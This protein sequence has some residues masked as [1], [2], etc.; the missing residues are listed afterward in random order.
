MIRQFPFRAFRA[1]L[2]ATTMLAAGCTVGPDFLRPKPPETSGYTTVSLATLPEA[3]GEV[4]QRV[5]VGKPVAPEWW[6]NFASPELD[7]VIAYA[8]SDSPTLEA[9]RANLAAARERIVAVRG[10]LFPQFDASADVGRAKARGAAGRT[11]VIANTYTVGPFVSFD[12]DIFGGLK[13]SVELQSALADFQRYELAAAYLALT[14][15]VVTQAITIASIRAQIEQ[16]NALI[17]LDRRTLDL[18]RASFEGGRSART[19]VL[20]AESQLT[21]DLTLLPPLNQALSVARHALSVLAGRP[22]A[23][24][25]PPDFDLDKLSAPEELPVT[26]PSE[27]VRQR[28]D[29]LAA[30]ATLHASS[31][32][33]GVATANLYPNLSLSAAWARTA[34]SPD[35]LFNP[36]SVI[37]NI[38]ASLAQPLFRGGTL[39]AERRA[40]VEDFNADLA[41][42]RDTVLTS[43]GQVADVLRAL[44]HDAQSLQANRTALETAQISADL[45]EESYRVGQASLLQ[46][47]DAQRLLF[48]ARLG[49]VRTRAQRLFDTA[50]LYVAMGGAWTDYA[51]AA[52]KDY[53]LFMGIRGP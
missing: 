40:A 31:A 1:A 43:F 10:G 11:G 36:S 52:P 5:V 24:W 2:L 42:Y 20:Q 13:R 30:E 29:I 47:I 7:Q 3:G 45:Q 28:P 19:D 18:T 17:A 50:Q 49:Y 41:T 4:R 34:A 39:T 25:E 48:Q 15:N 37:W 33:V 46:V 38:A 27:L 26:V 35:A 23:N 44:E 16:V 32:A 8:I 21:A 22:P 53:D 12:P 9:S 51:P 14:G 6:K